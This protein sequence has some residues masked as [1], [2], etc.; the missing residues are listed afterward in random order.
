MS[1]APASS[2]SATEAARNGARR[3]ALQALFQRH[4]NDDFDVEQLAAQF[5]EGE[6]AADADASYL[7]ALLHGVI[8]DLEQIDRQLRP[9]L[10]RQPESL[11]AVELAL[12]RIGAWELREQ[13]DV[14]AR[15]IIAQAVRLAGIFGATDSHKYVNAVLDRLADAL[16]KDERPPAPLSEFEIIRRYFAP[17]QPATDWLAAGIGEDCAVLEPPPGEQLAISTDALLEGVHF[18]PGASA[19]DVAQ[20]ALRVALSDLAACGARGLGFSLALSLPAVDEQWLEQFAAGLGAAAQEFQVVL[21][22]GNLVQG[23]LSLNLHVLGATPAGT[24]LRRNGARVGDQL[25]VSG[26]LGAAALALAVLQKRIPAPAGETGEDC[27]QR[28]WRPSPRLALG[29]ALQGVASAA[30]D[31]SDGLLADAGHLAAASGVRILIDAGRLPLH[32]AL[33][34]LESDQALRW[35]LGGGDDYELCFSVPPAAEE[36]RTVNIAAGKPK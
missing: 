28:Y 16:R 7:R 13:S 33:E 22:G 10:D 1:A 17:L 3:L 23:P 26:Q 18:P 29:R 9:L 4:F 11:G 24:A 30:I 25:Y 19:E 32:P 8:G 35:A 6:K 14:S 34:P 15:V 36:H 2:A 12:L 21:L 31:I 5:L 27:L 20:R